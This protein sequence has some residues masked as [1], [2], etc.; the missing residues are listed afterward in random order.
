MLTGGN[1]LSSSGKP[2]QKLHKATPGYL[3]DSLT[4]KLPADFLPKSLALSHTPDIN[5][6]L[7]PFRESNVSVPDNSF[8]MI[9][10]GAPMNATGKLKISHF[11][12]N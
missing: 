4:P 8:S 7:V 6:L 9:I 5:N 1:S 11:Q 3:E 10:V 12:V 2:T